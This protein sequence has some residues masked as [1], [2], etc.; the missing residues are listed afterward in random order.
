MNP[1]ESYIV[2]RV[3]MC[4]ICLLLAIPDAICILKYKN[5]KK[6]EKVK[7]AKEMLILGT[8]G[9]ILC[10]CLVVYHGSDLI[11]KDYVVV[12]GE[13]VKSVKHY[14]QYDLYF[15]LDDDVIMYSGN[16]RYGEEFVEGE[17]YEFTYGKRSNIIIECKPIRGAITNHTG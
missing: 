5:D 12:Q 1:L 16:A 3:I 4:L 2:K 15:K 8:I 13:F 7:K 11:T 9:F 10:L 6:K 17:L 14:D